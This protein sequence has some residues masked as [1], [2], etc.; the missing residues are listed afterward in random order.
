MLKPY[1]LTTVRQENFM[2]EIFVV[3]LKVLNFAMLDFCGFERES[4]HYIMYIKK[5]E[6][7]VDRRVPQNP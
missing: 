6:N 5:K 7:F 1:N 4:I 2:G 3:S